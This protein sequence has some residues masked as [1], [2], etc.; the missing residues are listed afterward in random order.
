MAAS[1]RGI[2]PAHAH[3]RNARKRAHTDTSHFLHLPI[4]NLWHVFLR[5]RFGGRT[6]SDSFTSCPFDILGRKL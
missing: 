3:L 2:L 4:W 1:A 6:L 5:A